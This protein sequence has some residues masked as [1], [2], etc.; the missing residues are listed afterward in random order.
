MKTQLFHDSEFLCNS[1]FMDYSL[2]LFMVFD[3]D[4]DEKDETLDEENDIEKNSQFYLK[5]LVDFFY[6]SINFVEIIIY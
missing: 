6:S 3:F 2:L 4:I 1:N 5:P